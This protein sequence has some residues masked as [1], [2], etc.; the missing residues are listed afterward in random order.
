[1]KSKLILVV[2]LMIVPVM[3][4]AKAGS[5]RKNK[6]LTPVVSISAS[7][8]LKGLKIKGFVIPKNF[9]PIP[10]PTVSPMCPCE[11]TKVLED[12]EVL[13]KIL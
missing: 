13:K 12:L 3:T 10:A 9:K 5:G 7:N 8:P 11:C 1:M 4:L 2:M 6:T